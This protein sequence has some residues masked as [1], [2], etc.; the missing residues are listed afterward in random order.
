M[1]ERT[2][3]Q[4]KQNTVPTYTP[5][6][7]PTLQPKCACGGTPGTSVRRSQDCALAGAMSSSS[8]WMNNGGARRGDDARLKKKKGLAPLFPVRRIAR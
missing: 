6:F 2:T 1:S 8:M 5:A 4:P 3:T 7:G